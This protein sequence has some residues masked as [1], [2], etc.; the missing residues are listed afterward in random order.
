MRQHHRGT[1]EVIQRRMQLSLGGLF[2]KGYEPL[3]LVINHGAARQSRQK[4]FLF[5]QFAKFKSTSSDTAHI[6][7]IK[8]G[9]RIEIR[10]MTDQ[11]Y[12]KS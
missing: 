7:Q 11:L 12:R 5:S 8:L 2:P 10:H 9:P 3:H 4:V 6:F 1:F